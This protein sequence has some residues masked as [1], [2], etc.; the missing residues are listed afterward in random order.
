MDQRRTL[1]SLFRELSGC[2]RVLVT[3]QTR[4]QFKGQKQFEPWSFRSL[5]DLDSPLAGLGIV[6][7][8]D[9]NLGFL[10]TGCGHTVFCVKKMD[11][12][13]HRV[14]QTNIPALD[15][16]THTYSW[17]GCGRGRLTGIRWV[18]TAFS[19]TSRPLSA[20]SIIVHV[21]MAFGFGTTTALLSSRAGFSPLRPWPSR[22]NGYRR[23]SSPFWHTQYRLICRGI[24]VSIS[25]RQL[26]N[27]LWT[28]DCH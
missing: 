23:R 10:T 3:D 15:N 18:P 6:K 26:N 8:T 7:G 14:A 19:A 16:P 24:F 11:S 4:F 5:S 20:W 2:V 22:K 17:L 28:V 9:R 1:A 21:T 25:V 27:P 13:F 12:G